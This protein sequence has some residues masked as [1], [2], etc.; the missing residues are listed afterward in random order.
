MKRGSLACPAIL[1]AVLAAIF[2]LT[3]LSSHAQD[4]TGDWQASLKQG[5][6]QFR[7][8]LHIERNGNGPYQ[9]SLDNVDRGLTNLPVTSIRRSHA[10]L[11]FNVSALG[12]SYSGIVNF[13]AVTE[14]KGTWT[15]DND[16]VPLDFTRPDG[17]MIFTQYPMRFDPIQVSNFKEG[18]DSVTPGIPIQAGE[19]WLKNFSLTVKNVSPKEITW[20]AVDIDV[21]NTAN[22]TRL[23]PYS[24]QAL[25]E[26]GQHP[27]YSRSGEKMPPGPDPPLSLP[28]GQQLTVSFASQYDDIKGS[29]EP[30]QPMSTVQKVVFWYAVLFA[31]GTKWSAGEYCRPDPARPGGCLPISFREFNQYS[32]PQ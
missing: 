9:A 23:R 6:S 17:P 14:I 31:D 29:V 15:Q 16:S 12:A 5:S 8:M 2:A 32:P 26:L 3:P 20:V 30:L 22:G 18:N 25:L 24:S 11:S 27:R 19:D 21:V 13:P 28:P 1:L 4:I 10:N 7:L